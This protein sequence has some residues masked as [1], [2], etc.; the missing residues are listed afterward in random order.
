MSVVIMSLTQFFN[1][2][3]GSSEDVFDIVIYLSW[4]QIKALDQ[5]FSTCSSMAQLDLINK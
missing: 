5:G 2:H 4:S 1:L 3:Q